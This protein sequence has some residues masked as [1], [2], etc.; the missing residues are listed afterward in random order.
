MWSKICCQGAGG[1]AEAA[2]HGNLSEH[3]ELC[4]PQPGLHEAH[5]WVMRHEFIAMA[6]K[7][8]S[9]LCNGIIYHCQGTKDHN[10]FTAK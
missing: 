1:G 7:P 4:K 6:W 3:A 5:D 2:L 10:R 9:S 8:S